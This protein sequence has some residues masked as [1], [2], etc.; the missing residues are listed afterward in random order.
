M[1]ALSNIKRK[2]VMNRYRIRRVVPD[3]NALCQEVYERQIQ[4][5][6]AEIDRLNMMLECLLGISTKCQ[7]NYLIGYFGETVSA[8]ECF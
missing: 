2:L 5:E 3:F 1:D 8:R 4:R 7:T 6:K